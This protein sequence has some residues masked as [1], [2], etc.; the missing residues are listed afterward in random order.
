MNDMNIDKICE[1]VS[2]I[3][4]VIEIEQIQDALEIAIKKVRKKA[5]IRFKIGDTVE[6]KV[7]YPKHMVMRG[8]LTSIEIKYAT[9]ENDKRP[10]HH[11]VNIES[12]RKGPEYIEKWDLK[13]RKKE[14][15]K[16]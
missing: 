2:K 4:F 3:E 6:A 9:F 14:D 16:D 12:L 1:V 5:K 15:G 8:K 7:N 10:Y 11:K 13:L